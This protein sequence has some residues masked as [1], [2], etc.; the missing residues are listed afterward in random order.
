MRRDIRYILVIFYF[1][2]VGI[3]IGFGSW[4]P[5]YCYK[6]NYLDLK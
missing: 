4:L 3:E 6:N 1:L 5:T 2:Y